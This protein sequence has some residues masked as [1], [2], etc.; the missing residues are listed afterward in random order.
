MTDQTQKTKPILVSGGTSKTGRRVAERL[1]AR[2][3]PVRIG[4]RSGEPAFDWD[5][6]STWVSALEGVASVYISHYLDAVPGAAETVGSFAELAVANGV[7]RQVLLGGRG[8]PEAERVE[9]AV[10]DAGGELTIVRST[11]FA[12]N[13]S[14]GGFLD[15]VLSGEVT[16]PAGDTPEPF[17]DVDDI[18][19]VA[20]AA[21]TDDRY[22]GE[23]YE[24]TGPRL[25]TFEE[26]VDEIARAANR[27][28]RYVPVSMEEFESIL[29]EAD[30]PAE[31]VWMLKYLFT[32][33]L[34]GRNA[35]V[36]D[37]VRRA[38]G[39]EPRDFSEY[40]RDA[41]ATGVWN[42]SAVPA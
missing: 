38:L 35:H 24:L 26:A 18:A 30:V 19:D 20:V 8:E 14:E 1:T 25:L 10:R 6:R 32:E 34:D 5:D 21:L 16:L 4:S 23:L 15:F 2:G 17:V 36:T 9:E 37:G 13:F 40:A 41:A 3:L 31:F 33:V 28:L 42:A 7:R 11:W 12:Q 22:V 39:R 27:E 29:T